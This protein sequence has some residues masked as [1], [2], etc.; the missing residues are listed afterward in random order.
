MQ[1][2]AFFLECSLQFRLSRQAGESH[3]FQYQGHIK[4]KNPTCTVTDLRLH[5]NARGEK[6][7]VRAETWQIR[8]TDTNITC[9]R[10]RLRYEKER[11]FQ[12]SVCSQTE[13]K[14]ISQ[15]LRDGSWL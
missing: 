4:K 9:L 11:E 13:T 5:M 1:I 10:Y 2:Q 15:K 8:A 6:N 12:T 14:E 7:K 3:V